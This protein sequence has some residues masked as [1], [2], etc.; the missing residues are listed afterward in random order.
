MLALKKRRE[1]DVW[2]FK[3]HGEPMQA[4]GIPDVLM[5]Y[6]GMFV[7][8]EFKVMRNGKLNVTPYQDYTIEKINESGGTGLVI[9]WD[10]ATGDVGINVKRFANQTVA[11]DFLLE[12]LDCYAMIS[13]T[14]LR[15]FKGAAATSPAI[16]KTNV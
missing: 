3:T 15:E 6:K 12:L 13:C 4:R 7:A 9:W 8:P 5:C 10:E 16:A 14:N 11:I 2:Y 1:K